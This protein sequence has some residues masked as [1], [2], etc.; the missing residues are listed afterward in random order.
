[1]IIDREDRD[2]SRGG[3]DTEERAAEGRRRWRCGR[4][5][6]NLC[7][8]SGANGWQVERGNGGEGGGGEDMGTATVF[9]FSAI[10]STERERAIDYA[11]DL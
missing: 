6:R 3:E 1:L 5:L 9:F 11:T 2:G 4:I 8:Q 10:T 7:F